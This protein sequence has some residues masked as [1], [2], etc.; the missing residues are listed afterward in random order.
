M[1][2]ASMRTHR[3]DHHRDE[4]VAESIDT[5]TA[6]QTELPAAVT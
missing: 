1:A 2:V 4:L 5:A 3:L 6:D